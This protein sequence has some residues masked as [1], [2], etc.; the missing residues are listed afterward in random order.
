MMARGEMVELSVHSLQRCALP[1]KLAAMLPLAKPGIVAVELLATLAGML[2][3]SPAAPSLPLLSL[4]AVV[5]ALSAGGA[6]MCNC[7]L[8]VD[9]DRLMPRLAPRCLALNV[10][11]KGMV[12]AV[13]VGALGA[14][15]ILAAL[16]LDLLA[17]SLLCTAIFS[18]LCLYTAW[19]KRRT[20]LAVLVGG[21]P[22]ALPPLIGAAAV[23]SLS[24]AS[25]LLSAMIYVWQLPHFGMLA[26][27]YRDQYR[28]AGIPVLPAVY[29]DRFTMRLIVS[30]AALLLSVPVG[31]RLLGSASSA[32]IL[33]LMLAG[34]S[35]L[36]FCYRTLFQ[37]PRFRE[38]AVGSIVYLG[39][40]LTAIITDC[41]MRLS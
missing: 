16:F 19:L 22:G 10:A 39:V 4:T 15:T 34:V 5:I 7:L 2:L 31:F 30:C 27:E 41:A 35:Y 13:S 26:F 14:S 25:L 40:V 32:C 33:F 8:E 21:I 37:G 3:A 18:Y 36:L 1:D 23:G 12:R 6:A 9:S 24:A 38:G 28:L 20:P 11:G 29:G 17:T